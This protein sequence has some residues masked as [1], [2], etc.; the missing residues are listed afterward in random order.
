MEIPACYEYKKSPQ[1]SRKQIHYQFFHHYFLIY[2]LL[3]H[4]LKIQKQ[5]PQKI[6]ELGDQTPPQSAMES[7]EH[8]VIFH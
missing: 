4:S 1:I 7:Y 6:L 2:N 5:L 3:A 8:D